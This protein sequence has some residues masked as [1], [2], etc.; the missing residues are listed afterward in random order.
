[1]PGHHAGRRPETESWHDSD[2]ASSLTV[3]GCAC[4]R[5]IRLRTACTVL[6]HTLVYTHSNGVRGRRD[7]PPLMRVYVCV[8]V[9]L[10]GFQAIMRAAVAAVVFPIAHKCLSRTDRLRCVRARAAI[11]LPKTHQRALSHGSRAAHGSAIHLASPYCRRVASSFG[12]D[13]RNNR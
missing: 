4:M 13:L 6:V 5:R 1:M 7:F 8:R 11:H 9:A 12:R 10:C 2:R 3:F